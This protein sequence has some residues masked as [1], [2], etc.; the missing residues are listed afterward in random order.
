MARQATR[1]GPRSGSERL[2]SGNE[3]IARGAWEAGVLVGAGY[4]GTP[5]TE[6]LEALAALSGV[7]CEWSPN[8]K[9]AL[10][11]AVGAALAGG[12]ALA[13]MKHVGLNVAADPLFSAAYMGVN[14]GLVV[15]T[16]DDPGMHSSQNEQDNR[17]FARA[18]RIPMLEPST[19]EEARRYTLAAFDLSERHDTPVLLRTAT[20]LSHGTGQ[21][22]VGER[23][24]P[25]R[26]PYRKDVRKNV[27]LPAHG[28]VRHRVIE[29]QRIP[30]LAAESENWVEVHEGPGDLAVITAGVP[31][32]YVREA[33]PTASVLKLGM[34]Y[35]LPA[36]AIRRFS[37][38]RD[39][40][41]VIEE[42]EPLL[43]EQIRG[44]RVPCEFRRLPR[45]GELSVEL[46]RE[47][48][49][50]A[51]PAA[52]MAAAPLPPRPP[53][54][55]PGCSHRGTFYALA[56]HGAIVSG[57]IG[58]YTLGA[59]APL[60]A[61]DTCLSMGASIGM[62]HGME[63]VLDEEERKRLVAVIGDSTFH[64]SGGASTVVV[65][66]NHTT[67]MTGHQDHPGTGHRLD[68]D[69]TPVVDLPALARAVGVRDVRQFD[70]YD[71]S[72]TWRELGDAM[73]S[74]NPA[75]LIAVAPCVLK[76][77]TRFGDAVKLDPSRCTDCQA[78][79]RLA[80]PAIGAA[81]L[82]LAVDPLLCTGCTHCQQVCAD[83]HAGIDVPHVLELVARSEYD[84]ALS[85]LL[86]SNP[87]PATSARV[88]PH[89]CERDVNALGWPQASAYAARHPE[90]AARFDDGRISPRVIERFLGDRALRRPP[91]PM[92]GLLSGAAARVAVVGSGPGG[93]SAAWQLR[94]AG[95]D[96]TVLES[97]HAPGGMLRH[98]I[99]D[100]RLPREVLDGELARLAAAGITIRCG[101]RVGRDVAFDT[102]AKDHDAVV[103]AVGKSAAAASR[104]KGSDTVSVGVLH[105][106]DLLAAYNGGDRPALGERVMVVGG[107]NT[108]V[109]CARVATRLGAR[110][111]IVYRRSRD[112]MPAIPEEVADAEADGVTIRVRALPVS[113][114]ASADGRLAAVELVDTVDGPRD[115]SGRSR[116]VIRA[117]SERWEGVDTIVLATGEEADLGWLAET[118]VEANGRIGVSYAGATSRPGVFACGDAAFGHGTVTQAVS[119]GRRAAEAAIAYLD[120]RGG[121]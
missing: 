84:R 90:L 119:T 14:G 23:C 28:R 85:V 11:V 33:F 109:D 56:Q 47:V 102:V 19:P 60:D 88:C 13:T 86:A 40:I 76:E 74:P 75:L 34:T 111:E 78:C 16:A 32:L 7:H 71:L 57:D 35:P 55:C 17:Y 20:R 44:L 59:L 36:E 105:G 58:C 62:A 15:V 69:A 30:G 108:A 18:A 81:G 21:V 112:D 25:V 3:A 103:L 82:R 121:Q 31:Y 5:S 12:R 51:A 38:A 64:H 77:A 104:L 92:T 6:I 107:G 101:V 73:A 22:T 10:E 89:P 42:L 61:M 83:C 52:V 26:R 8:E 79:T 97:T 48:V 120:G 115:A 87:L 37:V 93:L 46:L 67:A 68:G 45:Y 110:A 91:A 95:H 49:G 29:E 50:G 41:V 43:E 39:R 114:R 117:G 96:V 80:C 54:L 100:F 118:G 4:P 72:A 65:L 94:R 2:L 106:L 70:P 66:D 63:R 27:V 98:G 116:P 24:A 9:V 113:V 1:P 99:P 53:V